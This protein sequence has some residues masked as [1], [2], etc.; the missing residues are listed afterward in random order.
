MLHIGIE[1]D[2]IVCDILEAAKKA[3]GE[4]DQQSAFSLEEMYPMVSDE[5][6]SWWADR[7][8]TYRGM[9]PV[10][11]A[12]KS[13]KQLSNKGKIFFVTGRPAHVAAET[14]RWILEHG[15]GFI[16][17]YFTTSKDLEVSNLSLNI[18]IEANAREAAALARVCRTYIIDLPYN[19][20]G[21]GNAVR[22]NNWPD[23]LRII[24]N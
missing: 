11:H 3:F 16:P 24:D 14:E 7:P 12:I 1:L 10:Q 4:P 2:G 21:A 8:T 5:A 13:V 18:C 15:L 17:V 23:L 22:A 6:L 20:W 19:R 9:L